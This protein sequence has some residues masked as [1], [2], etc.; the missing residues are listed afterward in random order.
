MS[1]KVRKLRG[2]SLKSFAKK[3]VAMP[4]EVAIDVATTSAGLITRAAQASFDAG[5]TA[6][7][8]TRPLSPT[9][10]AVSLVKTGKARSTA[11]IFRSDGGT[12]LRSSIV[13]K[14]MGILVGV[15]KIL[16]I[17]QGGR[18]PPSWRRLM[19]DEVVAAFARRFRE[20]A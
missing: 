4:R 13:E 19:D 11:L 20:A 7:G 12:K 5:L 6:Y 15:Y 18:L 17:G 8:D 16:P 2:A 9:G 14:Y 10:R 3:L 1:S